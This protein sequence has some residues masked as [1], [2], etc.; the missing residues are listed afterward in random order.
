MIIVNL[1]G[2]LGNQMFQYACGIAL[3]AATGQ[4]VLYSTDIFSQQR[5]FNGYELDA[6]FGLALPS[7]TQSDLKCVLGRFGANSYAR[8]AAMKY[9]GLQSFLP[10]TAV[11]E[12]KFAFDPDLAVKLG[13]GGYLH[14]YWQSEDYFSQVK[15]QVYNSFQFQGVEHIS[16]NETRAT[17]VSLHVRRGDYMKTGSVH[18]TCNESY[19][20]RALEALELSLQETVLHVFSDD[21]NWAKQEISKLHQNCRFIKENMGS[22][23]YKDMYLMSKCDH[24][25]IANSSFSW[26]GAWLNK[27]PKKAVIAPKKWFVDPN[28]NSDNIIPETWKLV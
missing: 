13:L 19:Y 9:P 7:A 2:G 22:D 28:L 16:L 21:P 12:R 26:W 23:S 10:R 4:K 3:K 8:R 6:V 25:I 20:K 1:M 5:T 11:F 14:G 18:A 15:E 27:S 24:H 17:N